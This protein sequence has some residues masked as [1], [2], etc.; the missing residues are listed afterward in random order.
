MKEDLL[1]EKIAKRLGGEVE[2]DETYINAGDKGE[3]KLDRPPKRRGGTGKMGRV[4]LKEGEDTG[5]S[6]NGEGRKSHALCGN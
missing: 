1:A 4:D 2:V 3:K 5:H 6:R